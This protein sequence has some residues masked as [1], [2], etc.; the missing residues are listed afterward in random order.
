MRIPWVR[1]LS[2]LL[3]E[4]QIDSQALSLCKW[5]YIGRW[6]TRAV[7][8]LFQNESHIPWPRSQKLCLYSPLAA[9]GPLWT[10]NRLPWPIS[11]CGVNFM[12]D[13]V[14]LSPTS[15]L[16][17]LNLELLLVAGQCT[18]RQAASPALGQDLIQRSNSVGKSQM[19]NEWMN[20]YC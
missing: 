7:H 12:L 9:A 14:Q 15:C 18:R 16:A 17:S 6:G 20:E 13:L 2:R 11:I 4:R 10:P 5:N 3:G 1:Y 8:S 19:I